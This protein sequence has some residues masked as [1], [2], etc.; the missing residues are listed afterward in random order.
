MLTM[1]AERADVIGR[2]PAAANEREPDRA[3]DDTFPGRFSH[4]RH[5]FRNGATRLDL[6][7]GIENATPDLGPVPRGRDSPVGCTGTGDI[8]ARHALHGAGQCRSV[9]RGVD[10][11]FPLLEDMADAAQVRTDH[12]FAEG[13]AEYRDA[14]IEASAMT[15]NH[16]IGG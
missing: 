1:G 8:E 9:V 16:G 7:K 13:H 4:W 2:Y 12:D 15:Q 11:V 14:R 6:V 10:Q 3:S 5:S